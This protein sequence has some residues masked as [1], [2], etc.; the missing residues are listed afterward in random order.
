MKDDELR[1]LIRAAI[2][3]HMSL[4]EGVVSTTPMPVQVGEAG[5]AFAQYQIPRAAGD[6]MCVI[7]P[8]ARCNHCGYCKCHGH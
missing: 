3:R 7:E 5:L 6:S 8:D 1:M 4:D 2:R